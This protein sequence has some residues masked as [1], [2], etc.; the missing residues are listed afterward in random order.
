MCVCVRGGVCPSPRGPAQPRSPPPAE[1]ARRMKKCIRCQVVIGKKLRPGGWLALD[2]RLRA[3]PA[4]TGAATPPPAAPPL[5]TPHPDPGPQTARRWPARPRR[6]AR[7]GSWWRSCR[8][9]TGRWRSASP[10]P[11]ASTATSA[12]CSSAATA[13]AR[14]AAPRSAPAPFAASPSAIASRSSCSPRPP[15][16]ARL[17]SRPRPATFRSHVPPSP[18][19]APTPCFIKRFSDFSA[20]CLPGTGTGRVRTPARR[21]AAPHPG[22]PDPPLFRRCPAPAPES[23]LWPVPRASCCF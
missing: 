17:A 16:P 20:W 13:R 15:R 5:L 22:C 12:S 19:Q 2:P 11:S 1:C 18:S 3:R 6:P 9:A 4:P 10:A 14:P 21:A 23:A 7:R 8:A